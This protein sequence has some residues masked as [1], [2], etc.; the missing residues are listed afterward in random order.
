MQEIWDQI[1]QGLSIHAPKLIPHFQSGTT[2]K[3]IQ[4]TEALLGIQFP[5]D[6]RES[7]RIHNGMCSEQ[8]FLYEW[9]EFYSLDAIFSQWD[10]WR[11]LLDSGEFFD[12]QSQPK[13]PIKTDWWNI[14]W[15]PLLGNMGGD[16]YCLDLDPPPEG[17]WGQI[18]TMWHE[19]GVEEVIA[20]SLKEFLARLAEDLNAG[21][22]TYSE[23]HGLISITELEE[24]KKAEQENER[25]LARFIKKYTDDP[26][27]FQANLRQQLLSI[28]PDG[29]LSEME[30]SM[31]KAFSDLQVDPGE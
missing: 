29:N 8:K 26:S 23:E 25:Q 11:D 12:D 3:A 30:E 7:Y 4:Q 14:K 20:S 10:C 21:A 5:E 6:V 2:E 17:Q 19:V 31:L 1:H 13:G 27:D 9:P 18:I 24:H 16:H 15:I 28:S 22:Y